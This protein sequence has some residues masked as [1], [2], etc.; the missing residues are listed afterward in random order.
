[1]SLPSAT[2]V[3]PTRRRP[4]QLARCVA[5][6]EALDYPRD[7]LE[8]LVIDDEAGAGPSTARNR[9]LA[10]AQGEVV[11]FTDDDCEPAADWLRLLAEAWMLDPER[12]YGG[13]VSNALENDLAAEVA[14]RIILAGYRHLNRPGDARFLTSNNL[15]LPTAALRELGGFEPSLR[16]S[17]D[18]DLCDRWRLVGRRLD[19]VPEAVVRHRHAGGPREFWRQHVAYARGSRRYHVLHRERTGSLP[20]FEPSFYARLLLR[21][22]APRLRSTALVVLWMAA[23]AW[24]YAGEVLR[25][26]GRIGAAS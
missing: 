7:L 17:E 6:L 12:G 5:A 20:R 19:Q 23:T 13:T 4:Q 15:L 14:Q 10:S 1:M 8:I 18:R 11:A 25:P 9:G 22:G 16:T 26:Q 3:V 21:P 24:G 2:V